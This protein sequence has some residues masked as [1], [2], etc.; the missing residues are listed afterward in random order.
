MIAGRFGAEAWVDG[1]LRVGAVLMTLVFVGLL[2]FIPLWGNDFWLQARIGQ[3]II[4]TGS[5]PR[6]V[7]FPFTEAQFSSF[8][9][10][11][12]LPS[13]AF[14]LL[15][16]AFGYEHLVFVLGALGLL[17]F[18]IPFTTVWHLTGSLA[19]SL[20]FAG[21]AVAVAN[22]RQVL[23]PEIF[24]LVLFSSVLCVLT[25]YRTSG[26]WRKLAWV[27]PISVVWANTH[28]S[29]L[30]G[31]TVAALFAGGEAAEAF[32]HHAAGATRERMRVAARAGYP[33]AM[34]AAAMALVSLL[35]PL[36]IG[37]WH[38]VFNLSA[39]EVTK[40]A[41]YE[42]QPTFS[43]RFMS[44][45]AFYIFIVAGVGSLALLAWRWRNLRTTEGLLFLLF[46]ALAL[47]RNRFV[48]LFGFVVAVVCAAAIGRSGQR[49]RE[50]LL[51][52]LVAVAASVGTA[53]AI[54]FGNARGSFP[55]YSP[56]VN[57]TEPMVNMLDRPQMRGNVFNSYE[58]GAELIYRAYPRLRP[59]ID[60]R[61]DSY[62]DDYY[63]K[64]TTILVDEPRLNRFLSEY[65]VRYML[66][67]WRD[68]DYIK[69]MKT[70]QANGWHMEFA[71]HK[72]VLLAR[73]PSTQA[74]P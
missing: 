33:Y 5:I 2:S 18:A 41:I 45:P 58:L 40:L 44:E 69:G 29:F 4:E 68:F 74:L 43:P 66:L 60:S 21:M 8:N 42:W 46:A 73:Q 72:M 9:A 53:L 36:G 55:Y 23:R 15:D 47:E 7:L 16:K 64:Q 12:W 54:T 27:V 38:F 59:S 30:L 20:L 63:M 50:R 14:H 31:P 48:V 1:G 70:L 37:L 49:S 61:I 28:G 25:M 6:T 10:H 13:I 32:R 22:Y 65:H 35:N 11:E 26:G 52:V 24:A 71:D 56:S 39:S 51:L 67:L 17:L 34:A 3:M 19:I 57:F 62:G